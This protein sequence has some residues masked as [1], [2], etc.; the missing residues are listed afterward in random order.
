ML[1]ATWKNLAC[2]AVIVENVVLRCPVW[3]IEKSH[4]DSKS[5]GPSSSLF[6]D[7]SAR[8]LLDDI[9][10]ANPSQQKELACFYQRISPVPVGIKL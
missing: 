3:I 6:G 2:F 4:T 7:E 8:H 1:L 10:S 5:F 9:I